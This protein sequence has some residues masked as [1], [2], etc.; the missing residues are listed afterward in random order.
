MAVPLEVDRAVP[1]RFPDA[2][3]APA[4]LKLL[5][6][7]GQHLLAV[8]L[9]FGFLGAGMASAA[10]AGKRHFDAPGLGRLED[11]LARRAEDAAIRTGKTDRKH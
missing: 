7:Q 10:L 11:R 9:A 2:D 1:A 5:R 6:T 3:E 8:H 4:R